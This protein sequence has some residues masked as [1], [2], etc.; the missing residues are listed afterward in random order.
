MRRQLFLLPIALIGAGI[1]GAGIVGAQQPPAQPASPTQQ[2][3]DASQESVVTFRTETNFVEV[4]AIVTDDDGEFVRGL[5]LD[6]FEVYEDGQLQTPTVF[7]LVDVP[8]E[9]RFA[10]VNPDGTLGEPIEPDVRETTGAFEGR[11]F[12]AL[13]DDLHT[14]ISR[15]NIVRDIAKQF[16]SEYL[17]ENDLAGRHLHKRTAGVGTGAD[18]QSPAPD[19]S[20]RSLP[21]PQAAVGRR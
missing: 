7:S 1:I 17:G 2:P 15:T 19:G 8:I 20:H 10:P 18:Q 21:G 11:I 13:L 14:H 9:R 5:T 3:A 12:I 6:D 16:I 4:H